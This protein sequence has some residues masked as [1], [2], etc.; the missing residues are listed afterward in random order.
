MQLK[1]RYSPLRKLNG[2]LSR[3]QILGL[4]VPHITDNSPRCHKLQ[5]V[6][7]KRLPAVMINRNKVAYLNLHNNLSLYI[8]LCN[9]KKIW[10]SRNKLM[11][12]LTPNNNLLRYKENYTTKC[13]QNKPNYIKAFHHFLPV[14]E[15]LK[16]KGRDLGSQVQNLIS[17]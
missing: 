13:W 4:Q 14:V 6:L 5:E 3:H 7:R 9:Q 8:I 16:R 11:I 12:H 10:I 17:F 2:C 1:I 15:D